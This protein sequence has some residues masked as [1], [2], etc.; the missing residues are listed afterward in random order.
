MGLDRQRVEF[1]GALVGALGLGALILRQKQAAQFE[2][3]RDQLGVGVDALFEF[4]PG[5]DQ[6]VFEGADLGQA[7]VDSGLVLAGVLEQLFEHGAGL[8]RA[9]LLEV[10]VGQ[11]LAGLAVAGLELEQVLG[12]GGGLV[13]LAHAQVGAVAQVDG[14]GGVLV[15]LDE[16]V[17]QGERLV[18]LVPVAVEPR[19]GQPGVGVVDG[20][21]EL[22]GPFV[23][24]L[25]LGVARRRHGIVDTGAGRFGFAGLEVRAAAQQRQAQQQKQLSRCPT[26]QVSISP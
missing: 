17:E 4:Q 10:E 5:A 9:A 14:L 26:D 24:A 13:H 21:V 19:H 12:V 2:I 18:V 3:G 25:G 15:L 16:L 22:D 1:Q 23:V 8:A 20:G 6:I 7:V 11:R